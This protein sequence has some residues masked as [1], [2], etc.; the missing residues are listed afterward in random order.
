[1][2]D[3]VSKILI[4]GANGLL[5]TNTIILLL[6]QDY[7]LVGLVRNREKY[8]GE[9]HPRLT[10]IEGDIT[11]YE[12]IE[13]AIIGCEY[14]LHIAAITD[15]NLVDYEDYRKV[16]VIGTQHVLAAAVKHAVKRMV[17]VS[18]ANTF[19]YG[20]L[21]SLGDEQQPI[22]EP[23]SNSFYSLS[24]LEAQDFLMAAARE[25]PHPEIVIVNPSFMLGAYDSKPSSGRIIQLFYRKKIIFYPSG[26]KNFIHVKDAAQGLINAITKGQHGEAYILAHE[27]LSYRQFF[28]KL[29]AISGKKYLLIPIPRAILWMAGYIGDVMRKLGIKTDLSSVNMKA[30]MIKNF[31]SNQK[32]TKELGLS[33]QSVE[34]AI[35]DAVEWFE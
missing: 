35:E 24:K 4:T 10:L 14:V 6:E 2:K 17:F 13:K 1:M 26:G 20:S 25:N 27:N 11:K 19:G 32:T 22:K 12:D 33:Y 21:E 31:Y 30:L 7:Q 9:A 16:N 8:V 5:A 23:F 18:S 3:S 28:Q 29:S 34:Q 15:Q